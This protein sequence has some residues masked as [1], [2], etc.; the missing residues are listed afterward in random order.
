LEHVPGAYLNLDGH[1]SDKGVQ[2]VS[3]VLSQYFDTLLSGSGKNGRPTNGCKQTI[4][5][6]GVSHC[7]VFNEK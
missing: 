7:D 6:S 3:G 4:P 1:W 5:P 2:A